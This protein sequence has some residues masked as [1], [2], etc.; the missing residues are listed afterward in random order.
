MKMKWIV[1]INEVTAEKINRHVIAQT[2]ENNKFL[3]LKYQNLQLTNYPTLNQKRP[4][5]NNNE[6]D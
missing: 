6:L 2:S 3:H 4:K 1:M 5:N